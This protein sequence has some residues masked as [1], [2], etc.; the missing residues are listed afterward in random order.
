M[1]KLNE[2]LKRV[3]P[4]DGKAME[5]AAGRQNILT[6]PR[7]SLGILEDLSIKLAGIQ[8]KSLPSINKK[9][10]IVMASDHG[11]AEE[12]VSAFPSE[13]TPQMVYNFLT[14]GAGINVISRFTGTEIMVVDI[15]VG[16]DL[17]PHPELIIKKIAKGTA[18][19]AKGWAMSRDDAIL[20]LELGISMAEQAIKKGADAIGTG[21]M[22]IANTTS[23]SAILSAF[24]EYAEDVVGRGTGIDDER[25]EKKKRIVSQTIKLNR[26][27]PND[28]ID[29]LAKVGG[30][31]IGGIAGCIIGAAANKV[32]VVI[33]GFI[34]SAAALIASKLSPLSTN[35]MIASHISAEPGQKLILKEL[36]LRPLLQFDM[37]LGEGTGAVLGMHILELSA[38]ILSE[39]STFSDAKVSE[40]K[41]K[42]EESSKKA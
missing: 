3:L 5:K 42:K 40:A 1:R 4:L 32:P 36:G 21:D 24:C 33:D 17:K 15:G 28:P 39:M 35:Y 19:I 11:V 27:D 30:F 2:T 20:S 37:R 9:V 16:V 41:E 29:V 26:P 13:V 7:G 14:G 23:S 8:A 10:V 31:E 6:K 34:S 12:G 18:N 38:R 25:W 22:G